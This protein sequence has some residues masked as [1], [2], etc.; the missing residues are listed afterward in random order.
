MRKRKITQEHVDR[1]NRQRHL[2]GRDG[3]A[4]FECDQTRV[5]V[6]EDGRALEVSS[7]D[8]RAPKRTYSE[9]DARI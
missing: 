9:A 8:E 2:T 5:I 7:Y 1:I 6:G 3:G 4:S